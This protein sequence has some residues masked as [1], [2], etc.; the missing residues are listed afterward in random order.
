MQI[1]FQGG[2]FNG[3]FVGDGS[4]LTGVESSIFRIVGN[5]IVNNGSAAGFD[6]DFIIGSPTTGNPGNPGN[7]K[8]MFFDKSKAAFRAGGVLQNQWNDDKVGD[9]ST[10]FGKKHYC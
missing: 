8:R 7:N 2:I 1:F 4:G 3:T 5:A 6:K 9:F 10:A